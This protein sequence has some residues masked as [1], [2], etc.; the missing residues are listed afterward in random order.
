MSESAVAIAI[1]AGLGL[2]VA[3][4]IFAGA[5]WLANAA[6]RGNIELKWRRR[7]RAAHD[8]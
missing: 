6:R 3:V 4:V 1:Y 5:L 7:R 2:L 8:D